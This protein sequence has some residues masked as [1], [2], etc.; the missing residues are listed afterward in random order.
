MSTTVKVLLG[1]VLGF[2]LLIGGCAVLLGGAANEVSEN[3]DEQ[4]QDA[5]DD[6]SIGECGQPDEFGFIRSSGTIV[7]DSA[8]RSTYAITVEFFDE[9]G[10]R[11]GE[12]TSFNNAIGSGT[13]ANFEATGSL[14]AG[15]Q[16]AEC[17]IADV[18]RFSSE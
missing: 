3:M 8:D 14:E 17:A 13:T 5:L 6:A 12:A 10:T 2:L 18:T 4:Q 16:V 1:V 15:A 9:S 7:N 11:I